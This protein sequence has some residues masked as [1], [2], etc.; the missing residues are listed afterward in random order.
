MKIILV[1][2]VLGCAALALWT[3]RSRRPTLTF[4]A[5]DNGD[6]LRRMQAAGDN[7]DVAR[8]IDFSFVFSTQTEAQQFVTEV[9]A[10]EYQATSAAYPGRQ[11]WEAQ[12]T[13]R[14][15]P[16]HSGITE[17]EAKLS[18]VAAK[19]D[20]KADGWGSISQR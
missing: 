19:Y 10:P 17:L 20:G 13:H 15:V 11:M 8:D 2:A 12:V 5:D 1:L 14:M 9:R 18:T 4:P 6:V 7:L 3:L 16:T